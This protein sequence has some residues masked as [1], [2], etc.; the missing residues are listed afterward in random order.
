MNHDLI[1][2]SE[3]ISREKFLNALADTYLLQDAILSSTELAIISMNPDGTISSFNPAAE[4]LLGYA[5][6]E[7]TG[8]QNILLIH[9]WEEVVAR[10]QEVSKEFGVPFPAGFDSIILNARLKKITDRQEW[11]Y[12]RKDQSRIPVMLSLSGIRTEK[13]E[14]A[15]YLAIAMDITEQKKKDEQIQKVQNHLH[16][17]LSSIDDIAMEVSKAGAYKNI[18]TKNESL[19]FIGRDEFAGKTLQ[20]VLAGPYAHILEPY[21]RAIKKVFESGDSEYIEYEIPGS[22]PWRS[23]KISYLDEDSVLILIRDVTSQ[24]LTEDENKSIFR[25]SI[26]LSII[27]DLDGKFKRVN[28]S[29][30]QA[31]G[32]KEEEF[33]GKTA[34]DF[35]HPDSIVQAA[36]ATTIQSGGK[37]FYTHEN[38]FRCKDGSYRWLL[39][40]SYTDLRRKLIYGTAIDITERKKTEEALL[41]SK[42][43]LEV[44]SRELLEQNQRLNEFAHIISHNLR[45]P[46]GNINALI[47]LLD[48]N[49]TLDDYKEI[50]EKLKHTSVNMKE[51]L[52]DLMETLKIKRGNSSDLISLKFKPTLKKIMEDLAGEI[53]QCCGEIT[54]D[55]SAA[56]EIN[57]N[58]TYLESILLNLLSNAIKYRSLERPLKVHFTTERIG[59]DVIL[60]VTDNGLGI[61]LK[62]HGGKVFGLRKTFHEHK[63][64]KGVGLFLTKTQVESM[65]GRIWMESSPNQGTA[66]LIQF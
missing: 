13:D 15:G 34:L 65:G 62:Q 9:D 51:T 22:R 63:E 38:Q 66:V 55:F 41:L 37:S 39:W 8:K 58:K 25:N 36:D 44:A 33:I 10:A 31:L 16:A 61:D 1:P 57:Y 42:T 60:K 19:L 29:I 64:A 17:L 21:E 47:S 2:D 27:A 24:K 49:S 59:Q 5:S 11:T 48:D 30:E 7:L 56:P 50:F 6:A 46:V 18:W 14:L 40:S 23:A 52:N 43:N 4:K 45:S 28:P 32:W 26:A 12:I 3:I 35:L 53:L 54:F 20:H